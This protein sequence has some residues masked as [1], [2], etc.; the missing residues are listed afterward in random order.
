MAR[1]SPQGVSPAEWNV[2]RKQI[3]ERDNHTCQYCD[4]FTNAVTHNVPFGCGGKTVPE[5]LSATCNSCSATVF[6]RCFED[7]EHKYNYIQERIARRKDPT[8]VPTIPAPKSPK[9]R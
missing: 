8:F 7:F 5:N 4:S 3:L 2:I 6:D 1:K 9:R